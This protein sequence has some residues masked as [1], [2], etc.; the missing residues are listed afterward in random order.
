[1]TDK[2]KMY[3]GRPINLFGTAQDLVLM[4]TLSELFFDYQIEDP[5]QKKHAEGYAKYKA[6]KGT[7]YQGRIVQSGMDYYF[8]VVLDSVS[9]G[10]FV[11]FRDGMFGAGVYGEA[12]NIAGQDKSI[13]EVR[14]NNW[15]TLDNLIVTPMFLDSIRKLTP[16]QTRPRIYLNGKDPKD[17]IKSFFVD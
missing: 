8:M 5:S 7:E 13:Y 2:P 17:G 3:I 6:L 9:A 15:N 1:M 10:A 12:E 16:E 11:P 4:K 14:F